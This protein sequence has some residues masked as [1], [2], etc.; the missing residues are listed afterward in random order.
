M[1]A[2]SKPA[3]K[4]ALPIRNFRHNK[5]LQYAGILLAYYKRVTLASL[6]ILRLNQQMR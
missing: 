5:Q 6:K 1:A 4:S 2:I 3:N